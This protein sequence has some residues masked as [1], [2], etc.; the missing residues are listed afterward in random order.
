MG[1]DASQRA[2]ALMIVLDSS[3]E[4]TKSRMYCDYCDVEVRLQEIVIPK[5]RPK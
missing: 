4:Q 1:N 3:S 5:L 2:I